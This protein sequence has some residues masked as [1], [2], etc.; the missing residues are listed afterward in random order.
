ME[1]GGEQRTPRKNTT[2]R[3]DATSGR[4][5]RHSAARLPQSVSEH[6]GQ[7]RRRVQRE[8]GRNKDKVDWGEREGKE[9]RRERKEEE[10]ERGLW[11]RGRE[12]LLWA[13]FAERQWK[14]RSREGKACGKSHGDYRVDRGFMDCLVLYLIRSVCLFALLL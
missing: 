5:S 1:R 6:D 9:G 13:S 10:R 7:G 2:H 3:S 11:M 8:R 14:L 4:S 12:E